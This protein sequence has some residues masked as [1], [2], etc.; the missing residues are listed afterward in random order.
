MRPR[1][2]SAVP[3]NT[4]NI[5][6][7]NTNLVVNENYGLGTPVSASAGAQQ[8]KIGS[9]TFTAGQVNPVNLTGVTIQVTSTVFGSTQ[10]ADQPSK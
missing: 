2:V 7:P 1:T 4:L 9:Y 8:V 6:P 5:L 3:G 10:L